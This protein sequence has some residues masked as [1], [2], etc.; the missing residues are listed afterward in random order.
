MRYCYEV[1][2]PVLGI[3]E[4]YNGIVR[5]GGNVGLPRI[6]AARYAVIMFSTDQ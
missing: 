2:L 4:A 3:H 6:T 1:Y 5:G